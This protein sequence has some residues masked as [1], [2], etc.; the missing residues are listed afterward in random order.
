MQKGYFLM[1][2]DVENTENHQ[3]VKY[4]LQSYRIKKKKKSLSIFWYFFLSDVLQCKHKYVF[5]NRNNSYIYK[6]SNTY[7]VL[8]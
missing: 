4:H 3:E 1:A 8:F 5:Q 7:Q 2:K 6:V